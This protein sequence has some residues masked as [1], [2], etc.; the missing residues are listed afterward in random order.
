MSLFFRLPVLV[1]LALS[2]GACQKVYYETMEKVGVHKRD[3]LVDRV[4]AARDS[5]AEA[6]EEFASALERFASVVN[7]DGGELQVAYERLNASYLDC[8]EQAATVADRI[9]KVEDVAGALFAEWEKEL[10]MYSNAKLR[11]QSSS[12]LRDT[13]REYGKMVAAMRKAEKTMYPVLDVL[14]DQVLFL[15]HNLNARAIASIKTELATVQR[16]VA[17]LVKQMESSI[18][19]ANQ[20]ITQMQKN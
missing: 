13:K 9:D 6:K 7:F 3:I 1:M 2:L 20:F 14:R 11:D 19:E 4:E 16:D 5:Q 10:A 8:E 17:A 15:K 18:A 12:Q